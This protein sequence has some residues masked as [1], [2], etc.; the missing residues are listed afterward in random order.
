M[1]D[2]ASENG[3]DRVTV[4]MVELLG[5]IHAE[6]TESNKRLD[7]LHDDVLDLRAEV[8]AFK[9]ETRNTLTDLRADVH[10]IRGELIDLRA[11]VRGDL[12]TRVARLENAVFQKAS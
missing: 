10:A 5:K 12:A 8:H 6:L 3:H 11:E 9:E 2:V 4:Q 1:N 7:T